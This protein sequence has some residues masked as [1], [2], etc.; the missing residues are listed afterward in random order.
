MVF[1]DFTNCSNHFLYFNHPSLLVYL[2][3]PNFQVD[4]RWRGESTPATK[5]KTPATRRNTRRRQFMP[6]TTANTTSTGNNTTSTRDNTNDSTRGNDT[7]WERMLATR[8][9]ATST[10]DNTAAVDG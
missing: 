5:G 6:A 2:L 7:Q 9:I 10:R 3:L 8:G 1:I 4:F